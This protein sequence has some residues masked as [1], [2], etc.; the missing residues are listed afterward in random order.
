MTENKGLWRMVMLRKRK[1]QMN[2]EN[3]IMRNCTICTLHLVLL[4]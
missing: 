3:C 1:K 2:E 4:G